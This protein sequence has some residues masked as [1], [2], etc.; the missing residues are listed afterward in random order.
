MIMGLLEISDLTDPARSAVVS[1]D[2][3]A[4]VIAH[5][6]HADGATGAR[7]TNLDRLVTALRKGDW[8]RVHAIAD[9]LS[10][11]VEAF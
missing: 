10:L 8:P 6:L 9:H 5:W 4:P 7:S 3:V 1:V 11:S 2:T